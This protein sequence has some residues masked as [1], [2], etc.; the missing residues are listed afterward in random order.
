MKI[1][2][3]PLNLP[4]RQARFAG[5]FML[6]LLRHFEILLTTNRRFQQKDNRHSLDH[7]RLNADSVTHVKIRHFKNG[8][9]RPMK[10]IQ[11]YYLC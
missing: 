7:A 2:H 1:I 3:P 4:E 10:I 11:I 6:Q 8:A 9:I 5:A